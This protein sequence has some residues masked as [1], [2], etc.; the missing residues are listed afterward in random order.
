MHGD[1]VELASGELSTILIASTAAYLLRVYMLLQ[2]GG[3]FLNCLNSELTESYL[4][5]VREQSGLASNSVKE[6]FAMLRGKA[7]LMEEEASEVVQEECGA[8]AAHRR[9]GLG[10]CLLGSGKILWLCPEHQKKGNGRVTLL[11]LDVSG[12]AAALPTMVFKGDQRMREILEQRLPDLHEKHKEEFEKHVQEERSW[13]GQSAEHP[14][15]VPQPPK[16]RPRLRR[17]ET[18]E[19]LT[20]GAVTVPEGTSSRPLRPKS[21]KVSARISSIPEEGGEK[22]E[23]VPATTARAAAAPTARAPPRRASTAS[24]RSGGSRKSS[25]ASS[26]HKASPS[27][28]G[29]AAVES[30]AC[31]ML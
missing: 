28:G 15:E 13:L 5:L 7:L 2:T 14:E 20:R 10:R 30:K 22:P 26:R 3:I 27:E 9:G 23:A 21:S 25:S 4:E 16:A 6:A 12:S 19:L 1:A 29:A 24:L 31:M 8:P 18:C 17:Q 11:S